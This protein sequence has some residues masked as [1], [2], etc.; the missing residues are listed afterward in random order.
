MKLWRTPL[1][2]RVLR[3]DG[4]ACR[5]KLM[6][7]DGVGFFYEY[8]NDEELKPSFIRKHLQLRDSTVTLIDAMT[9]TQAVNKFFDEWDGAKVGGKNEEAKA[10]WIDR[11]RIIREI[12]SCHLL[13]KSKEDRFICGVET[14]NGNGEFGMCVLEGYDAPEGCI[15]SDYYNM[16]YDLEQ[17][18]RLPI[19]TIIIKGKEYKYLTVKDVMVVHNAFHQLK[20]EVII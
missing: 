10:L 6:E 12:P 7:L 14:T 5:Q 8:N 13:N 20:Q 16:I 11:E 4:L 9:V 1:L 17:Q 15:I 18:N 2:Q 3:T 19:K